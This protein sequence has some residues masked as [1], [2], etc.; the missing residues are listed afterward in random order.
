MT[1]FV[2]VNTLFSGNPYLLPSISDN[3][4]MNWV[5]KEKYSFSV[6]YSN[7]KNTMFQYQPKF[8]ATTKELIYSK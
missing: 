5:L 8:N 6:R 3:L 2:D 7:D 4:Q 1:L